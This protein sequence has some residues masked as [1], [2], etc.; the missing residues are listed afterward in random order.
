MSTI[1]FAAF[2]VRNDDGTLNVEASCEKFKVDLLKDD[3]SQSA[4]LDEVKNAVNR[5]FDQYKGKK[6]PMN[7]LQ[8]GVGAILNLGPDGFASL[9][10][11]ITR[12]IKDNPQTFS[13]KKGRNGGTWRT[14]D[15]VEKDSDE[16]AA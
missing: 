2:A 12:V 3:A 7:A 11:R 13:Q 9:T 8:A 5:Y 1:N 15:V 14:A 16:K 6:V 4:N 10:E